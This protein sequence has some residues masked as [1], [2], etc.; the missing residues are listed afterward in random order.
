MTPTNRGIDL[1]RIAGIQIAIDFSWVIIFL[2]VLFSLAAGYFP[3]AYP[4]HAAD[5]YWAIGLAATFL[6]FASVVIHELAH[7]VVANRLGQP[8]RRITL[9][10]FGGMAHLSREPRNPR[11][12][13]MIAAVG[14]LTSLIL[15]GAF[16]AWAAGGAN[17]GFGPLTVAML[18]YLA[19][20]NLAL[21]IFN[22]LPGFPLDGGRLLRG[23]LWL[24][25]GDLRRATA[26]AADWG[27]GIAFGLM[28]LG[29]LQIFGGALTGGL[30]L[31]FIGMFLRGAARA[32]Y[33][34]VL[35]EEALSGTRVRDVMI[36]DP[37]V[38]SGEATVSE[39]VEDA[40]LRHGFGGF[41]VGRDHDIEG[42]VSLRQVRALRPEER[43][44]RTVREVMQPA[45]AGVR[46]AASAP[47]ADALRRMV[48][49][50]NGRLLVTDGEKI[51]GLV[52]RTGITRFIQMRSEL[53]G[54]DQ[55]EV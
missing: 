12:E 31:I 53:A 30:W 37:V 34:A 28:A 42:L 43:R 45:E 44:S 3:S 25:W 2:L 20:I 41:P 10:V 33:G 21:A 19:F 40:F 48:D 6:F 50:E 36:D 22:L 39:V 16:W 29:M 49:S 52:T 46:V 11:T 7:A 1:V 13:M 14:P 35:V 55:P 9:F 27:S 24:R 8:V 5:A 15:A 47:I 38:V 32:S 26:R 51:V 23:F 17:A 54:E 18:S 4:G